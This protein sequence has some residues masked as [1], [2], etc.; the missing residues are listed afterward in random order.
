MKIVNF[1]IIII[2]KKKKKKTLMNDLTR[3][4][5]KSTMG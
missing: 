3:D 4:T 2:I 5:M 1:I